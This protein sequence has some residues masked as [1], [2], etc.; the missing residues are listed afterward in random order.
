MHWYMVGGDAQTVH[1]FV[2]SLP[3]PHFTHKF[4]YLSLSL[5][6]HTHTLSFS[7]F[8]TDEAQKYAFN[9]RMMEIQTKMTERALELL[10]LP[11]RKYVV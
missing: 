11:D 7:L 5:H 10:N 2:C 8:Y 3:C 1:A 9:S 4:L 6:I